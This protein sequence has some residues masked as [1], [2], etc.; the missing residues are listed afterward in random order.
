MRTALS[1][2]PLLIVY[3]CA[4][5]ALHLLAD[6][7]PATLIGGALFVLPA[8]IISAIPLAITAIVTRSRRITDE[9]IE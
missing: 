9:I 8:A 3:L 6:L 7:L 4:G 5:I 1:R 2:S